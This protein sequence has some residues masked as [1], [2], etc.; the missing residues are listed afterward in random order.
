MKLE[1]LPAMMCAFFCL[2]ACVPV[3]SEQFEKTSYYD[4]AIINGRIIDPE[5]NLDAI[6]NIGLLGDK[7]IAKMSYLPTQ[8]LGDS[9]PQMRNKGR[10]Q[11]GADADIVIFDL[12][13]N[14]R[15]CYL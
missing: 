3:E 11:E 4:V 15:P 12:G 6:R 8:I 9:V 1:Y 5:T 14:K 7:I 10:I 2:C 13:E